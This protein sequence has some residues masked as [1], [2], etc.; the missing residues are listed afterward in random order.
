MARRDPVDGI[1]VV[2]DPDAASSFQ[3]VTKSYR[4]GTGD[5]RGRGYLGE[6]LR[7]RLRPHHGGLPE[8]GAAGVVESDEDLTAVAVEDREA[9]PRRPR[10]AD[11]GAERVEGH[12]A[13]RPQPEAEAEAL[14]GGDADP[15]PGEGPGAD[16]DRDQADRLPAAG[17]L[18]AALDL[19]EE[20]GGVQR[21]AAL[22]EP[23]VRLGDDL[24]V[25]PGAGG[26]VG[27]RGVEAD[28]DQ[29][30]RPLGPVR[31]AQH[32]WCRPIPRERRRCRL[33]GL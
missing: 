26:G 7:Q 33:S 21:P 3:L 24:A 2:R 16:P 22:V 4:S 23:E 19:A 13:A 17:G 12:D 9:L 28:D 6:S 15:Q 18:G 10:G 32:Y 30:A 31:A 1:G 5:R 27:G 8:G 29:G 25:A 11:P 14:G 20:A